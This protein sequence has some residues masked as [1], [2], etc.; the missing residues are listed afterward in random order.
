MLLIEFFDFSKLGI[1]ILRL[2]QQETYSSS[3][4]GQM[5]NINMDKYRVN[6]L[7]YFQVNSPMSRSCFLIVLSVQ[8][9]SPYMP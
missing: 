7:L 3:Q 8:H 5:I 9:T 6:L 4:T 2:Y 1:K